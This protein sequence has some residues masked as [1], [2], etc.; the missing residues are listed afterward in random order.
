M[1]QV[2]VLEAGRVVERG[3]HRELLDADGP[4][5]RMAKRQALEEELSTL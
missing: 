5:A 3:S 1:D 4:Y 2:V